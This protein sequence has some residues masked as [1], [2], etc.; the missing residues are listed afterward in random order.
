M[1]VTDQ[2]LYEDV[3]P[4][5]FGKVYLADWTMPTGSTLPSWDATQD[6]ALANSTNRLTNLNTIKITLDNALEASYVHGDEIAAAINPVTRK[7]SGTMETQFTDEQQH[8]DF[9]GTLGVAPPVN[10]YADNPSSAAT[11]TGTGNWAYP[12]YVSDRMKYKQL[13][14]FYDNSS[15]GYDTSSSSYRRFEATLLGVK[16]KSL[17]TPRTVAGIITQTFEWSALMLAPFNSTGMVGGIV[18]YDGMSAA[19]FHSTP[20]GIGTSA[21]G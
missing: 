2:I 5:V 1:P 9:L 17:A 12:W 16:F 7:W 19:D 10:T 3:Y 20:T 8:V 15:L 11:S 13:K 18:V 4:H 6:T 14:V 21:Y